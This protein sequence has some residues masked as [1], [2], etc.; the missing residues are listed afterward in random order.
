MLPIASPRRALR[1]SERG[2]TIMQATLSPFHRMKR[3]L[4]PILG[5][6]LACSTVT[7]A[8]H[9]HADGEAHHLCV[10]CTASHMPA[11]ASA[12]VPTGP[13]APG[14]TRDVVVAVEATR[15]HSPLRLHSSRAPP[16]A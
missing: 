4:G 2:T 1:A 14:F 3:W 16:G 13:T 11:V 9:R 12:T 10:V 15:A 7:L 8:L 5:L 6:V